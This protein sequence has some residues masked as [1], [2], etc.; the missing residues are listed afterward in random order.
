MCHPQG[1]R[2]RGWV[3][4]RARALLRGAAMTG[5][6]G[7]AALLVTMLALLLAQWLGLLPDHTGGTGCTPTLPQP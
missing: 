6:A 5:A 1:T 4:M 2:D 7:G 3:G